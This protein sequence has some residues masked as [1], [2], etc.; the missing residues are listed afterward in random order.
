VEST[1]PMNDL[2]G[3]LDWETLARA[4]THPLRVSVL[5]VLGIDGGRT[6]APNELAC[7][8]QEPASKVNYH[9]TELY[10]AGQ[11]RRA[12]QMEIGGVMVPFYCLPN[13]SAEDLFKRLGI[14]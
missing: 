12:H 13:H 1:D 2:P 5:E 3:G 10:K 7:E 14:H 9:A 6:L 8:L 11:V 4:E